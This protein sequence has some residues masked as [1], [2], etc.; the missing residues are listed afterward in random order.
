MAELGREFK[1]GEWTEI[2]DNFWNEA[3]KL[4]RQ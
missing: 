1:K 2:E 4:E 3:K